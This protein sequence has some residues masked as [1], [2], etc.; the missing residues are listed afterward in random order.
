M[1]LRELYINNCKLIKRYNK[2]FANTKANSFPI[3]ITS[4]L[5]SSSSP[6]TNILLRPI[7]PNIL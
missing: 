5:P 3:I 2:T 7:Y 6:N 4:K 1:K